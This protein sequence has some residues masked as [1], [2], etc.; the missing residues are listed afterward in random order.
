MTAEVTRM[1]LR[2]Q[3]RSLVGWVVGWVALT[4]LYVA[5]WP[6]IRENADRY[7]Q[8]FEDLPGP[9]RDAF[10]GASAYS[11]PEGYLTVEVLSVTGPLLVVLLAVLVGARGIAGAEDDG[12]LDLLLAQPVSRRRVVVEQALTLVASLAV[13]LAAFAAAVLVVGPLVDLGLPVSRV[14]GACVLL[15]LVGLDFGALALLLGAATGR[16]G[17]ARA[18][19]AVTA[20][21][22]YTVHALRTSVS[23]FDDLSWASPFSVLLDAD[24]LA[25][26]LGAG[27][28]LH[29]LLP[30]VALL[31]LALAAFDRRDVRA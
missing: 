9:L 31:L 8:I 4:G 22:L 13:V 10:G 28:V 2:E 23:L 3:R 15:G 5:T 6:S 29:L 27:A 25:R 20:V 16:V 12:T 26:P 7:E 1:A 14:A 21:L 17:V 11:T 24:P 30:A 18:A 19:P